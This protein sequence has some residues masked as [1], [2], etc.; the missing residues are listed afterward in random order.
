[1]TKFTAQQFSDYVRQ[2]L[3]RL[4]GYESLDE[5]LADVSEGQRAD[6]LFPN[7]SIII[8]QKDFYADRRDKIEKIYAQSGELLRKY[9][10]DNRWLGTF[11]EHGEGRQEKDVAIQIRATWSEEDRR[12]LYNMIF[13]AARFLE[14]DLSNANAQI[15]NTKRLLSISQTCGL[16]LF[17]NEQA[18][19]FLPAHLATCIRRL[20]AQSDS[21]NQPR[22]SHVDGVLLF[23]KL[24]G[25]TIGGRGG[26]TLYIPGQAENKAVEEFAMEV[27]NSFAPGSQM[28]KDFLLLPDYM[29]TTIIQRVEVRIHPVQY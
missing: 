28:R 6:Y 23:Q 11:I 12:K 27:A 20:L 29:R 17:A 24:Q 14:D 22:F 15:R 9:D 10:P 4:P 25:F 21:D 5:A 3:M 2:C 7:R 16:V 26:V 18:G 1:M 8:E 13:A 19:H